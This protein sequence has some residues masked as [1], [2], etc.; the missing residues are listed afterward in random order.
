MVGVAS[1]VVAQ[2]AAAGGAATLAVYSTATYRTQGLPTALS[3]LPYENANEVA[4][5]A[6]AQVMAAL[7]SGTGPQPPVFVGLGA[8]DPRQPIGT[9]LDRAQALGAAGVS[10][11]P[12]LAMF[13]PDI[14]GVMNAAGL[15]F[16][17]EVEL[18]VQARSRGMFAMGWAFNP[19]EATRFAEA[20][21]DIVGAM[22][23]F[24]SASATTEELTAATTALKEIGRAAKAVNP[25]CLVLGHGGPF[26]SPESVIALCREPEIDGFATGSNIE[27]GVVLQAVKEKVALLASPDR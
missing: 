17:K 1:G 2:G 8:H 26:G 7:G 12:F 22:A 15:G 3:F 25:E 5:Q 9:L 20:G 10:N 27:R 11:E 6:L 24:G 21:A 14:A 18:M 19:A 13:G 16:E 23:G 4:L